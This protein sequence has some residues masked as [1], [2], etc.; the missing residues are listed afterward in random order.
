MH[1]RDRKSD[2]LNEKENG[3]NSIE[4]NI[5]YFFEREI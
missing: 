2:F 5:E 4:I 3:L 1:H